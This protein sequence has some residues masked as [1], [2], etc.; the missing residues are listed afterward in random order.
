ADVKGLKWR[1][2]QARTDTASLPLSDPIL[3]SYANALAQDVLC[4]WQHLNGMKELWLFWFGD[5]PN[6]SN[7]LSSELKDVEYGT[8]KDGFTYRCRIL[9]FK[10][11]HNSIERGLLAKSFVRYGRWF[12]EPE[13]KDK[14]IYS[15]NEE[16]VSVAFSFF[17]FGKST[18]C[19]S[20]EIQHHSSL[21]SLTVDDIT[22]ARQSLNGLDGKVLVMNLL[23]LSII[24]LLFRYC[25]S[26][27]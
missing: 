13:R 26:I 18:V 10:A 7:I 24:H 20:V 15:F 5:D 1:R 9:L 23:I 27:W 19:T 22:K 25:Y 4:V 8:F 12:V 17:L 21:Y 6:L 14:K 16:Q 11:I 2:Y 3:V